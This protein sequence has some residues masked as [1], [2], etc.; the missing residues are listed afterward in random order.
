MFMIGYGYLWMLTWYFASSFTSTPRGSAR[1]SSQ[2]G[3]GADFSEH[4][5][6]VWTRGDEAPWIASDL[7]VGIRWTFKDTQFQ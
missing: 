2:D 1:L 5:C 7:T 3:A 4:R 6:L